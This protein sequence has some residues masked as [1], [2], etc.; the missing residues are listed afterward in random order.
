MG[1]AAFAVSSASAQGPGD[2]PGATLTKAADAEN[3]V[4]RMMAFDKDGDGKLTRAEIA[5]KRLERL[6]DRAD[7]DK[8]G[9]VTKDELT[10]LASKEHSDE[11]DF[12]GPGGPPGGPGGPPPGF[13]MGGVPRPGE[14]LPQML[15]RDLKLS[16][17][18]TRELENLQKEVDQSLAKILT[19]AQKQQ[20]KE[21]SSRGPRGFG[22]PGGGRRGPGGPGRPPGGP[23]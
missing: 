12:G 16:P 11:P 17:E 9:Q 5:D 23:R 14:I 21:L 15:R 7:A 2:G 18:Q 13:M 8:N 22:P 19:D 20:L 4:K 1:L 6:F 3:L 10:A